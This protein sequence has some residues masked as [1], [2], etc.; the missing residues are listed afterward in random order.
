MAVK[1]VL[2]MGDPRLLRLAKPVETFATAELRDLLDD[3]F[4]TMRATDGVG[5]AAPQIGVDLQVVIFGFEQ[6]PR[7]PEEDGV[8][9]TVLINPVITP[10]TDEEDEAWEGCL[11]V[12]GLRGLVPRPTRVRYS[13]FDFDGN[14]ID[15][16]VDG[17]HA[18][19]VQ[20]EYDHLI[21][22]LYPTRMRD[23]TK[24]GYTEVL[25]PE[26]AGRPE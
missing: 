17:F 12:P 19:V 24:F 5:I 23:L 21:G 20:H 2:K 4:D 25:F 18:R 8:P 7:Y 3:L 22:R 10:L 15:R 11:S 1:T 26:S 6:N 14:L 9:E 16:E 13:G